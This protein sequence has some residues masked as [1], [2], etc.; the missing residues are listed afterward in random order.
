[1]NKIN[2]NL[3]KYIIKKVIFKLNLKGY[4]EKIILDIIK[5]INYK[6]I[7]NIS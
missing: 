5:L 6:L 7:F 4:S 1:M 2:I 3:K